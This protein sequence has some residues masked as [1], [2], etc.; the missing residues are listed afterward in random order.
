MYF[1][2]LCYIL[3]HFNMIEE[4]EEKYSLISLNNLLTFR[5]FGKMFCLGSL[6][7]T[8]VKYS[9]MVKVKMYGEKKTIN[10]TSSLDRLTVKIVNI[11]KNKWIYC[12]IFLFMNEK[13]NQT[14]SSCQELERATTNEK[15]SPEIL[16]IPKIVKGKLAKTQ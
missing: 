3:I 8:W 4:V 12:W 14:R 6:F 15:M 9:T 5:N 11:L 2:D 13:K 1:G 10:D 7:I 16:E